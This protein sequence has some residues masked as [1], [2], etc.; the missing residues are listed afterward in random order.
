MSSRFLAG[1]NTLNFDLDFPQI[2]LAKVV[3]GIALSVAKSKI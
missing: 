2:G 3:V 1:G